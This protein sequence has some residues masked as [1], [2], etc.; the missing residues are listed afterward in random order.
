MARSWPPVAAPVY[1]AVG[2]EDSYYGSSPLR[3]RA[4]RLRD[5]YAS[6]GL[7]EEET[8]RLVTLDVRP[9]SFFTQAGYSDQH[10]GGNAFAFD[11]SAMGWLF[12]QSLAK[13]EE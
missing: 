10:A 7:D 13:E 2:E 9:Q 6:Q 11:D 5:I 1:M 4:S 3:R 12:G 8:D